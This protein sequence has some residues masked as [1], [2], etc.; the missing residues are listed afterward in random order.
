MPSTSQRLFDVIE[1]KRGDKSIAS[2]MREINLDENIYHNIKRGRNPSLN[3]LKSLCLK[4][5][6]DPHESYFILTGTR[7]GESLSENEEGGTTN[8][9]KKNLQGVADRLNRTVR[10]IRLLALELPQREQKEQIDIDKSF[11]IYEVFSQLWPRWES[12]TR[13]VDASSTYSKCYRPLKI[14]GKVDLIL[15]KQELEDGQLD[16]EISLVPSQDDYLKEGIRLSVEMGSQRET[17]IS[18]PKTDLLDGLALTISEG[19]F[20]DIIIE[21]KN[22]IYKSSFHY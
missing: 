4:L 3:N 2:F 18:E 17:I 22:H 20:F 6:L 8:N 1:Q 7:Y 16:I 5:K 13:F 12:Q 19:D 11:N 14:A 15:K 9:L 21:Y 10:E